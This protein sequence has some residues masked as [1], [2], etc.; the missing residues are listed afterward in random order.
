M[1]YNISSTEIIE[2][3]LFATRAAM[4]VMLAT[5]EEPAECC[6]LEE[7]HK[8]S[9]NKLDHVWWHGE[10]SG[11]SYE[12]FRRALTCTTGSAKIVVCWEGGDSYSGLV[13]EGGQ[14]Y[15]GEVVQT[16][17]KKGTA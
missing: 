11:N 8:G 2:G 15:E 9:D 14:V 16:V 3:E 6:F 7:Q 12:D 1:A 5:I 13:V 4:D 10:W 17:Q